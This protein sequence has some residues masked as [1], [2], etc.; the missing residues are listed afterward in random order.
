MLEIGKQFK[1]APKENESLIFFDRRIE[2]EIDKLVK[3][4]V[5]V[6]WTKKIEEGGETNEGVII[7]KKNLF[8]VNLIT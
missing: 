6:L 4:K 7:G 1:C 8:Q 2:Y 5:M 3:E